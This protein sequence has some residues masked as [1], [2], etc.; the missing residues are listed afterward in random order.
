MEN[1]WQRPVL[2]PLA[3]TTDINSIPKFAP[4]PDEFTEMTSSGETRNYGPFS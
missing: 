1:V 2:L 4:M 3:A